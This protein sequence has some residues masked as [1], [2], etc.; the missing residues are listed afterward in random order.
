MLYHFIPSK[1]EN[2]TIFSGSK[3]LLMDNSNV[4]FMLMTENFGEPL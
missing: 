1:I 3:L 2:V 4:F